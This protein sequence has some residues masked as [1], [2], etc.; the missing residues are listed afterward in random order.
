MYDAVPFA[1][2][3]V[4][5]INSPEGDRWVEVREDGTEVPCDPPMAWQPQSAGT[6]AA[7]SPSSNPQRPRAT[8]LKVP[9]AEKDEAKKLGARWDAARKKW[10]VPQGVDVEPFSRWLSAD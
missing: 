3:F 9:Y 7:A 4:I 1:P 5:K 10:Y 8:M 6:V 2:P